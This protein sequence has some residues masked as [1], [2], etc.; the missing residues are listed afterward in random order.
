M[1]EAP[2]NVILRIATLLRRS[3]RNGG[4]GTGGSGAI[5]AGIGAPV[6]SPRPGFAVPLDDICIRIMALKTYRLHLNFTLWYFI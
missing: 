1:S 2:G 6:G 4:C 3:V 5:V